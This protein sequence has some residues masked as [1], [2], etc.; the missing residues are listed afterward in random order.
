MTNVKYIF[1]LSWT[2]TA[3]EEIFNFLEKEN[4]CHRIIDD[5]HGDNPIENSDRLLRFPPRSAVENA[6][7]AVEP[8]KKSLLFKSTKGRVI[9]LPNI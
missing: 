2:S 5:I 1:L 8:P 9:R 6:K 4:S 3:P 7:Y